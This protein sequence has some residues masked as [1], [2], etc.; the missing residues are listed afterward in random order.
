LI[1]QELR[2]LYL[3]LK[4]LMPIITSLKNVDFKSAHFDIVKKDYGIEI[5]SDLSQ[6][7]KQLKDMG[8]MEIVDEII[9]ISAIA[10]KERQLEL[11]NIKM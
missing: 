10:T 3:E 2:G 5:K 4:P 9:E 8:V 7:L 1:S 11:Q 6:S